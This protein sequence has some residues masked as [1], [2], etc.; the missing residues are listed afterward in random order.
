MHRQVYNS[1]DI[2]IWHKTHLYQ[3]KL[4]TTSKI[5]PY[6]GFTITMIKIW[7]RKSLDMKYLL[8]IRFG[9][10]LGFVQTSKRSKSLVKRY[11][12]RLLRGTKWEIEAFAIANKDGGAFRGFVMQKYPNIAHGM[13]DKVVLGD[14]ADTFSE[15]TVCCCKQEKKRLLVSKQP[16]FN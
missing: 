9:L 4:K 8:K 15:A 2:Y 12:K 13:G 11:S 16:M 6:P 7:L 3:K 14:S 10:D 1:A 5:T